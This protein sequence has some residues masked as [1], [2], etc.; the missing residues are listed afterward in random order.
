M[1]FEGLANEITARTGATYFAEA[2]IGGLAAIT[3]F[4]FNRLYKKPYLKTWGISWAFFAFSVFSLGFSTWYGYNRMDGFR[5]TSTFI[6]QVGNLL[7][8]AFLL[9]GLLEYQ[10]KKTFSARTAVLILSSVAV[11]VVLVLGY[12]DR[13]DEQG[14][15]NRYLLRVGVRYFIIM[16]GFLLTGILSVRNNSATSGIGQK[17]FTTSFFLYALT[18]CYYFIVAFTNYLGYQVAFP[19]FFGMVEVV[20]ISATALG[21]VMWLLEDER[22]RLRNINNELDSFLYRTSHDLRSP[23]ASILGITHLAQLEMT[24]GTSKK[25]MAMIEERI[26][27][28]DLVISDIL[29]LSRSKKLDLKLEVVDFN[30]LVKD[31]VADVKFNENAS[32]IRLDYTEASD[33]LFYTD[34]NQM[35]IV[36]G[37][38]VSNAV[39]YHYLNQP[40]PFIRITR[41]RMDK[42]VEIRVEDNG[43]GIPKDS[44][45]RIFEMFYRASTT[46]D[47]TGLGLYIVR[48]ALAKI[49]GKI[50][51]TS[52]YGK[53]TTFTVTLT[54]A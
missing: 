34:Y 41:K 28:L 40:D 17:I 13:M 14:A 20:L 44:L 49:N 47:G 33:A 8:V 43:Q 9:M 25:Y 7:H 35:K 45:P 4:Y 19:F 46:T 23:I 26:K 2:L 15:L 1:Q 38:L 22:E 29:K 30:R 21:M 54:N 11:S 52:D 18:Y 3:F 39:K 53:G 36:L 12:Y 42:V 27:R 50:A 5:L 16:A 37:N 6:T 31:V 48:E 51:V 32:S 10:R 24:D